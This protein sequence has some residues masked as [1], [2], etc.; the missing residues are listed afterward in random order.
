MHECVKCGSTETKWWRSDDGH[1][2]KE[3][4][5]CG[6]IGGPYVSGKSG[7]QDDSTPKA[8]Q[9]NSERSTSAPSEQENESPPEDGSSTLLDF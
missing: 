3:C 9:D 4:E 6:H 1:Y 8:D 2:R 7:D 5:N